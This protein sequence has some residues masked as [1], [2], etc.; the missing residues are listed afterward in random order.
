M[1]DK[2]YR[3]LIIAILVIGFVLRI[4][5]IFRSIGRDEAAFLYYGWMIVKGKVLYR[6]LFDPK[7]PGVFF[8]VALIFLLFGKNILA[9][10]LLSVFLSTLTA[11]LIFQIG[12][13]INNSLTGIIAAL[14]F[15][16]EPISIFYSAMVSSE[17]F[18][19]F[20]MVIAVYF[21]ILAHEK[22]SV[23]HYL[24]VGV[25]I[26]LSI[27]MKQPGIILILFIFL[28]RLHG[29][30][31]LKNRLQALGT[32]IIGIMISIMPIVV[33]FLAVNSL[34]DAIYSTVLFN[35]STSRGFPL[36][37][38]LQIF[39]YDVFLKNTI[40]WIVG[41]GGGLFALERRKKWDI[42]LVGWFIASLLVVP[43]LKTP[44]DHYY[45]QAMP[46]FCLLG[47]IFIGKLIEISHETVGGG[48]QSKSYSNIIKWLLVSLALSGLLIYGV[49]PYLDIR[50]S[51]GLVYQIEAAE[52]I[53]MHTSSDEI[54]FSPDSAYYLLTDRKNNYE[55]EH[56]AAVIVEAFG[57]SDLP[58]YLENERIRYVII[59]RR[60]ATWTFNDGIYRSFFN[61]EDRAEEVKIV[62]EW[63]L[64]NYFVEVTFGSGSDE[65]NIYHSRFW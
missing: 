38:R 56:F 26:G 29:R 17:T 48:S 47:G 40:L 41:I 4:V 37:K 14:L 62:Y 15:E 6:D 49:R 50:Y 31:P 51:R 20:F 55:I 59:D 18:M 27:I 34:S 64:E 7:P 42:F 9:I 60:T 35:L 57:I 10:R 45:I 61:D 13:K 28:H 8:T 65:I 3:Y 23:W 12:K 44:W 1:V 16:L 25:L 30:N 54:I 24:L 5:F 2:E 46:A 19:I 63:I 32:L 36:T 22:N 52:Y 43:I 58:Q 11:F 21:Y 33:Y 39:Y 53:K